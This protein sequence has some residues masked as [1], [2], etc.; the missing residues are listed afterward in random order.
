MRTIDHLIEQHVLENQAHL[1]HID[2]LMERAQA[3][4]K[5]TTSAESRQELNELEME[6]NEYARYV[7]ELQKESEEKLMQTLGPMV[8]W[9]FIAERLEKLV[10]RLE[11]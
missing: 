11:K 8:M 1:K 4:A 2:E 6:R 10:E 3:K 9:Q 7:E 5:E